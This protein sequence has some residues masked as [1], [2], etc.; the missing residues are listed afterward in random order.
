MVRM[1]NSPYDYKERESVPQ[2]PRSAAPGR[3][4]AVSQ[5]GRGTVR[6]P[7]RR[8]ARPGPPP[9]PRTGRRTGV[10]PRGPRNGPRLSAGPGHVPP[11]HGDLD[12]ADG[13]HHPC[14]QRAF[15]HQHAVGR[16][17]GP[18]AEHGTRA[19]TEAAD[20]VGLR[21]ESDPPAA[22]PLVQRVQRVVEMPQQLA[23]IP[24]G[25]RRTRTET[26]APRP[27]HA[28]Q[29]VGKRT[30]QQLPALMTAPPPGR[31]SSPSAAPQASPGPPV[32]RQA[33]KAAHGPPVLPNPSRH[34]MRSSPPS[35][36]PPSP[37]PPS[38]I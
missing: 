11:V 36:L 7:V 27:G 9:P 18:G 16:P 6:R 38:P 5:V 14:V 32:A 22:Q 34:G 13:G 1:T 21:E 3:R 10:R 24:L 19:C 4:E 17:G 23:Q 31:R 30:L 2:A 28:A 25:T 20:P 26:H 37:L 8:T 29:R 15:T 35:P 12:S 33:T